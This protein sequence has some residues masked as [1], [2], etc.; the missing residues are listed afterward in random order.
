MRKLLHCLI[1]G[2]MILV[3]S[4]LSFTHASSQNIH[5]NPVD[6]LSAIATIHTD[7]N[8]KYMAY[9]SAVAHGRR[10]RKIEKM[11]GQTLEAITNSRYKT[12]ELPMFKKDN[13][14]RQSSIEYIQLCYSVFNEDYA[15]IVNMEEIAEQSFDQMQ[16]YILLQEKTNEK[17]RQASEKMQQASK[18][19]A[20]KNNVTLIDQK[21]ELSEKMEAAAQ[22]NQYINKVFL[23]YFKCNWQ[24]NELIKAINSK[25][26]T[27]IEQ[28]RNSIIKY[29]EEG[30]K[31]LDTL[32]KFK[33]DGSLALA[34]RQ[35]LQYYRKTAETDIPKI[36]DFFLLEENFNKLKKSID[37]KGSQNRTKEDIDAFNKS[38]KE[39]NMAVNNYNQLNNNLNSNRNRILENWQSTEKSF[40]DTHMPYFK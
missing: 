25:K 22:L 6:Y 19:F 14:L 13:T 40:A 2:G 5:E 23:I 11:R 12:I 3:F 26:V 29:A 27:D 1:C 8:A 4:V 31:A 18:D 16:A 35:A 7:M 36:T 24:D 21:S 34:C 32:P 20:A 38:V 39:I 9:M 28:A 10:A 33:G 17:I 37:A 30:L 15:R